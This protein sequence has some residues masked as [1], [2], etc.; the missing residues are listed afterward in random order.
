MAETIL[1]IL[2]DRVCDL[3]IFPGN[4]TLSGN[5]AERPGGD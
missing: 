4:D 3:R 5:R 1:I 2:S